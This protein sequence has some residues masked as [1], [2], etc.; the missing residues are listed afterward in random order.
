[1]ERLRVRVPAGTSGEFSSSELTFCA[2]FYSVSVP[3]DYYRSGNVKDTGHS[4]K[5]AGGRSGRSHISTHTPL[6]QRS[7]SKLTMLVPARCGNVSGKLAHSQ[8]FRKE[9]EKKNRPQS[10]DVAEPRWTDLGLK[11]SGTGVRELISTSKR[12]KIAQTGNESSNLPPNFSRARKK[13]Q[14][15]CHASCTRSLVW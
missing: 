10:S 6:T 15:S 9:K 11:K 2:D 13:I 1:M 5:S 8:F 12:T 14:K 3:P 7:W 4:A